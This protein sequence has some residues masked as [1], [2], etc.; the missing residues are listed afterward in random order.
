MLKNIIKYLKPNSTTTSTGISTAV[1]NV[2]P[3]IL[4]TMYHNKNSTTSQSLLNK[5]NSY[6]NPVTTNVKFQIDLKTNQQLS[7]EDYD[8]IM[9]HLD[10]HPENKSIMLRLLL[11]SDQPGATRKQLLQQFELHEQ[12]QDYNNL[13]KVSSTNNKQPQLPLI[14]DYRNKLIANDASSFNR[15]MANYLRCGIQNIAIEQVC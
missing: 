1:T 5:L 12:L 3:P 4:I 14:I 6:T 2:V 9:E 8:F 11:Q 13:I 10:I 7:V 15:I